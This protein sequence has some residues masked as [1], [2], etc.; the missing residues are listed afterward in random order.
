MS[1]LVLQP[2]GKRFVL[3]I[4]LMSALAFNFWTQSRYPSLN[5]KAMM[6]GAIQLE[7]PISYEA[8]WR[9][10]PEYPLWKKI[11]YTTV[12]WIQTNRQGMTFGV[13]FG[14]AFLTLFGYLRRHSLRGGF[15]NSALGMA[16]GAPLGV[17]VNCA[18]PIAKG[19]YS[20]GARAELTL[21]AMVASP[22]LNVVVLTMLFSLLPFYMAV[23]KIALSLAVILLVV[24]IICRFLPAEQLQAAKPVTAVCP[25]PETGAPVEH[26]SIFRAVIQFARDYALNLWFIIKLTVPLMLLAG[27]LGAVIATILPADL[28]RDTTF[29]VIGL[30]VTALVGT[31]LPLPMG[32]DVV[33]S[34]ALLG[35]GLQPGYVMVLLFTLGIFSV[36]SFFIVAGAI[37]L[38]AATL[39]GAV[40]VALGVLAGLAAQH[41]QQWQSRRA[42]E[43][44]T[45]F[46]FA[47]IGSA[48]AAEA[49]PFRVIPD[50]EHIIRIHR[51]PFAERSAPA[52]DK[53][54]TRMEARHLGIDK[55]LEFSFADMWPPFWEGRSI[56]SGDFDN[57]GAT[58]LVLASTEAGLY[59][60]ANG[61]N[62]RF[63]P[64]DFPIGPLAELPVFNAA[65]VDIDNDGWLDLFVA[66]YRAGNFILWNENGAFDAAR[67]TE[68]KNRD[69]ALLAMALAFGDV[70]G[71][72]DLDLALG[73]WAA[74]WYRRI[75][76]EEA[77]NRLVFNEG[78]GL[79]GESYVDIPGP[80]GET[81]SLLLS[82]I[83]LDGDLD[84]LEGNDFE[85]PDQ[86]F[87]GDGKGGF[88][89]ISHQDGIIPIT[90]TT[91]MAIKSADLHND[92]VPEIYIAQIAGRS[93][94]VSGLKLRSLDLY[95]SEIER[96]EERRACQA[97]VDIKSWYRSGHSFDPSY[98]GRCL[99]FSGRYQTEC[100]A[101]LVKDLAIQNRD[102]SVCGLIP[103]DQ[104]R[105]RQ[106]CEIHFRPARQPSAEELAESIPQILRRNV[107]L[108]RN[109]D[110][111]YAERAVEQGL[112]VG[113]WS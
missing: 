42:L 40:I 21:S 5:E 69:D 8:M 110:G 47:P 17:C 64:V 33:A 96:E 12:N 99:E 100:K 3:A 74:G 75:P 111:T 92:G 113:G 44:L 26:E 71:D 50:G 37:S 98:A 78:G 7:D 35:G 52:G 80:P 27:F 70:D 66:T 6:S 18:A 55:P 39:L 48:A 49:E 76:G 16:M 65:L 45:S 38:R 63:S 30:T 13:L 67:M 83:D 46:D 23:A 97:N 19:L 36:Y 101:M 87:L 58:D 105:A 10:L 20:G 60:Y 43:I 94:G 41:Y 86:F 24:P 62:G 72:G 93:S 109:E 61:G 91:T 29:G 14:A 4:L 108:V 112:E 103:T 88:Q 56:S 15:S 28:L 107:L 51:L 77:T 11:F 54:F 34:A 2:Y 59:F 95:C 82:D 84:W 9:V 68:V 89:P 104:V 25:L 22:T 106:L 73:N 32:L 31:F 81:L 57:D 53:P 85:M 90:T 79:T 102:A 1:S